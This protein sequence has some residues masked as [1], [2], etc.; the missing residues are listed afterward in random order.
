V[1]YLQVENLSKSYGDRDL[2]L[3][4]SFGLQQGQ[5]T[6]L[7]ARNGAGKSTLMRILSGR[8]IADSGSVVFRRDIRAAWLDQDPPFNPESS[9]LETI[10]S[11]EDPRL[12]AIRAYERALERHETSPSS[13]SLVELESAIALVEALKAWDAESKVKE[14]LGRLEI[15]N[16]EAKM[17]S[18]SGGQRKR[19]AL[20]SV[21]IAEPDLLLLDE[22]TN[23]LDVEM[24]EWLESYLKQSRLTLL[25]ITHDRY[26]LDHVCTD[27]LE[28]DRHQVYRYKGNYA[29]YLEKKAAATEAFNSE[30][31]KARNLYT[32]ELEWMRRMPKARGTKAKARIDDFYEIKEKASQRLQNDSVQLQV[33]TT[34][35]GGKILELIKVSK[36]FGEKE[37]IRP[38]TYTFRR[39][40]KIGIAGKNGSGKSTFLKLIMGELIPDSGKIQIGE[41]VVFGYY[42]Q[43]GMLMQDDKR[44]IEVVRDIADVI[45][46][47]DGRNL[48]ASGLLQMFLFPPDMQY[49]PVSK[50]SGGEKRRLYLLTVLMRNPN[51]LILDEPTNDLDIQ[52]LNILQEFLEH[53]SGCVLIVSHD[54]YFMDSLAEHL[55]V[56]DGSGE[57]K[58]FNGNYS[59]FRNEQNLPRT[60]TI[61]KQDA[62][63]VSLKKQRNK[64]SFNE[65][66]EY[67]LLEK[68]IPELEKKLEDLHSLLNQGSGDHQ[69]LTRIAEEITRTGSLLD[70]KTSRWME[71]AEKIEN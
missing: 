50:L 13:E 8:E 2:F 3:N 27:I 42:S 17:S 25:M 15:H 24:I 33:K 36:K 56:F 63:Q 71:L 10:F 48:S 18:L 6:A 41:T 12:S 58:D 39:G 47:A 5:K 19:V 16:L 61:N 22:P 11:S 53:F 29:Y 54:R 21:L 14:V 57:I 68:E 30:V 70:E 7:V 69:E 51:F 43:D 62:E 66:H 45:P 59:A 9:I 32:R 52:T 34:R 4:I 37:I 67:G 31:D 49:T 1:N 35:L 40:E 38:F 46:M 44:V 64:A 26:F 65:V 20:A 28:L 55:F 23:H 60:H